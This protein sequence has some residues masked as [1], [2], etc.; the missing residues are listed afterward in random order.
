MRDRS[1]DHPWLRRLADKDREA[2]QVLEQAL[3]AAYRTILASQWP[4]IRAGFYA[5]VAWRARYLAS[6]G[7]HATLT[8]LGPSIRWFDQTLEVDCPR[9]L[10][11]VLDGHGIVLQPSLLWTGH[12]LVSYQPDGPLILIY[13]AVTP[14][15][16]LEPVAAESDPLTALLG[17]TRAQALQ[18]LTREHTTSELARDLSTTVAAASRQA[19]VL[20]QA[21]LVTSFRDGKAV[22]H[23][24]THL[25]LDLL[26][27]PTEVPNSRQGNV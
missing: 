19:K 16:L 6:Y 17:A 25:G 2:W 13:P 10:N 21:G 5:E 24:C 9:N 3:N 12:P 1:P 27:A 11:F 15:P 22:I 7:L 8:S 18:M 14:L 26:T 23:T 4:S 20:R